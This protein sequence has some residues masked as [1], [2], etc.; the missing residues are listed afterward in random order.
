MG[1]GLSNGAFYND[2][3]HYQ[4]SQWDK[5]Y[6]NNR[7]ET[8]DPIDLNPDAPDP[9]MFSDN[10]ERATRDK[11]I[12]SPEQGIRNRKQNQQERELDQVEND[13]LGQPI[14]NVMPFPDNKDPR[15][16]FDYRF[17]KNLPPSGILN[18]LKKPTGQT[19]PL[20]RKIANLTNSPDEI[21][22]GVRS[23]PG[24]GV[25]PIHLRSPETARFRLNQLLR[26][27]ASSRKAGHD[28]EGSDYMFYN[29]QIRHLRDFLKNNPSPD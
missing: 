14:S 12:I 22:E 4:A 21:L 19:V 28:V 17:P 8:N 11:N 3:A 20:V 25:D 29:T 24:G 1:I 16:D 23:S 9:D 6:D 15:Q 27:K 10:T 2:E 5:R 26:D 18:D 7:F 13:I